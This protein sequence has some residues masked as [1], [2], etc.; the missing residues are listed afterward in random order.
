MELV[1]SGFSLCFLENATKL[2]A[3]LVDK[4]VAAFLDRPGKK[5]CRFHRH[6]GIIF[7]IEL[8]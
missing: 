7:A 3:T 4:S 5:S 8:L 2:S 6:C 1:F